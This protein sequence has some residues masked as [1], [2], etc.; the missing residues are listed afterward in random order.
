[1]K[2]QEP[3]YYWFSK[4]RNRGVSHENLVTV[5]YRYLVSDKRVRRTSVSTSETL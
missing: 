4:K 5:D 2:R 3:R 1:M